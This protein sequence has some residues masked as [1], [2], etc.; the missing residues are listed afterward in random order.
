MIVVGSQALKVLYPERYTDK[1]CR[2]W[3]FIGSLDESLS[4]I[5]Q[6][7]PLSYYPRQD[8]KYIAHLSQYGKCEFEIAWSDSTGRALLEIVTNY[9]LIRSRGSFDY[10]TPP[11]LLALKLS[12]RYLKNSPYFLKTMDDIS[13]LRRQGVTVHPSLVEWIK[14]REEE[15]YYYKHPNLKQR[16]EQFFSGDGIN[17]IYNHDDIHEAI[18]LFHKPA[19][20]FYKA[21]NEE[22]F[23]DEEKFIDCPHIYRIAGVLEESY[24][25]ALERMLIPNDFKPDPK[26]A[27]L[28]AL[29]KICTS[30]TS[31]FFREFAWECYDQVVSSYT[32]D[33]VMQFQKALT[34]GKIRYANQS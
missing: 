32:V 4:F 31:G 10:V 6:N 30:I 8:K 2:D 5:R 14:E 16:K 17:Y 13:F 7:N 34:E 25:L 1:I 18:K 21:N 20:K 19:Y 9:N 27:F 3:D 23:C 29:E 22:V 11:V 28:I 15:T 24:V 12:H 33:F 26:K